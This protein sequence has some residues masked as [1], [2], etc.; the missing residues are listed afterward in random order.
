[1]N[2]KVAERINVLTESE[3]KSFIHAVVNAVAKGYS[4]KTVL[5]DILDLV[6]RKEI[7]KGVLKSAPDALRSYGES[8]N[9]SLNFLSQ[10]I[11]DL[12]VVDELTINRKPKIEENVVEQGMNNENVV[13]SDEKAEVE[14]EPVKESSKR[15]SIEKFAELVIS[16]DWDKYAY[17][18]KQN[19]MIGILKLNFGENMSRFRANDN[20]IVLEK[21]DIE[22]VLSK[23]YG[24]YTTEFKNLKAD[25][26][27]AIFKSDIRF[28]SLEKG[29]A[30]VSYEI[31]G[32]F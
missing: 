25:L 3:N 21:N 4:D 7:S 9:N 22:N 20:R 18:Q 15:A 28:T 16:E 12:D 30:E 17:D 8:I 1:M 31:K 29:E 14:K 2:N 11:D 26:S 19:S 24:Y 23:V 10:E 5:E 27:P 13:Q 6:R 32:A